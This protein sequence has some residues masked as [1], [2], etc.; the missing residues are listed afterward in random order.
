MIVC[1]A[2]GDAVRII[3]VRTPYIATKIIFVFEVGVVHGV[4]AVLGVGPWSSELEKHT[5]SRPRLSYFTVADN[6]VG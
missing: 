4:H 1:E 2:V 5:E 6:I 3:H